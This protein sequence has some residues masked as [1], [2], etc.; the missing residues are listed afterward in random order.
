MERDLGGNFGLALVLDS[1]KMM[2]IAAI[3]G[4]FFAIITGYVIARRKSTLTK[5]IGFL[6]LLPGALPGV[7]FGIGYIISFNAPFG[8][9]DLALTGTIWIIV[10][11]IV[12]TRLYAGVLSTQ[13]VLQKTDYS[14]EEAAISLGASRFY[15]FRRVVFPVLKR[16][17]L[18][19]TLFI[20][21]SGLCALSAVIFLISAKHQL[22][23]VA[24]YLFTE[25]GKFG[26]AC[27]LSTYLILVVL[28]VMSLIRF[29]E[30]QGKYARSLTIDVK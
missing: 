12:F 2:G 25:Q 4:G 11:L 27:A 21:V 23:S 16:P 8:R 29:I 1:I 19:S 20:F 17:W 30:K 6:V 24:I 13:S 3:I 9:P 7:V 14:M 28:I 15:T 18:L 5:L 26:V 10:L 22:A